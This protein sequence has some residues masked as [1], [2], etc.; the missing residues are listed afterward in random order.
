MHIAAFVLG[1]IASLLLLGQTALAGCGGA[2]AESLEVPEGQTLTEAAGI[3]F[4]ASIL[5]I[6]GSSL[7]FRHGIASGILLLITFLICLVGALTTPF[8]DLGVWGALL[9]LSAIFAF[10]GAKRKKSAKEINQEQHP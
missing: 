2:F 9:L 5:G 3:G 6:I 4:V 8:K 10:A 7:A 1:L